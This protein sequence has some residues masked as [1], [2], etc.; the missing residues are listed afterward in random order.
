MLQTVRLVRSK[1]I[2]I[3]FITQSPKDIP[4]DVLAQLGSKV[5]HALRAHTPNEAKKLRQTL[6]TFPTSPL[7]LEQILPNLG[8]GEAIVT[9]LDRKGHLTPVA[10]TKIAAT[11][12][13]ANHR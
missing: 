4:D 13:P 7:V 10:P 1:G 5:Q 8:T 12:T 9:V 2:G 6:A 3:I 11:S